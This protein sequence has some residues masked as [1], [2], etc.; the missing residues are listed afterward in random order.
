ML[1]RPKHSKNDFVAPK[2]EDF[3]HVFYEPKQKK[4]LKKKTHA[5]GCFL[6]SNEDL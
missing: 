1:R 3:R 5:L 4:K 6:F 2:E